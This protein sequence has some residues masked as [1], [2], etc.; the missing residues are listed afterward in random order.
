MRK[1]T[2]EEKIEKFGTDDVRVYASSE[3]VKGL[4]YASDLFQKYPWLK[5]VRFVFLILLILLMIGLW[6]LIAWML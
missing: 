4:D 1:R 2:R 6:K 3:A 5:Y